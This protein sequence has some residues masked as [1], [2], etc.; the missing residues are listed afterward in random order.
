MVH[1][2]KKKTEKKLLRW[3]SIDY[4]LQNLFNVRA[5]FR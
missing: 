1:V 3:N 2:K 4:G 5:V